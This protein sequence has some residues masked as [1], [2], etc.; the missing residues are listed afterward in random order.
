MEEDR[1]TGCARIDAL[2]LIWNSKEFVEEKK[3]GSNTYSVAESNNEFFSTTIEDLRP[4][5]HDRTIL[6][7]V[8]EDRS[9]SDSDSIRFDLISFL[10]D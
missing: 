5:K 4:Q 3:F 1:K 6:C 8:P 7:Y 2:D 10:L 9:D